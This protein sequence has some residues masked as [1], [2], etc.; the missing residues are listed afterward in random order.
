M[1]EK[2]RTGGFDQR[3]PKRLDDKKKTVYNLNLISVL[4]GDLIKIHFSPN[5][6]P[7]A[8]RIHPRLMY[9]STS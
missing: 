2:S 5:V 7:A 4:A 9:Q 6:P 3:F 8:E 1:D